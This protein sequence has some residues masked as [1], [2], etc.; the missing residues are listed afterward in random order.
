MPTS[1][2][3][4][5]QSTCLSIPHL[6]GPE[7]RGKST[8]SSPVPHRLPEPGLPSVSGQVQV[9]YSG[10]N[11]STWGQGVRGKE[12]GTGA[13]LGVEEHNWKTKGFVFTIFF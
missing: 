6:Q 2:L 5:S 4:M 1:L 13:L 7:G 3:D 9:L 8:G 12:K 11:V 10:Q